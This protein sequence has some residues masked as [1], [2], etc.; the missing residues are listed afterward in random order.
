MSI[1]S[2]GYY[3]L[4]LEEKGENLMPIIRCY[5][6]RNNEHGATLIEYAL[7]VALISLISLVVLQDAASS[8]EKK[9]WE[10]AAGFSGG[11]I[12][13]TDS[14][15]DGDKDGNNDGDNDGN[16]NGDCTNPGPN[17]PNCTNGVNPE[18]N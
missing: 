3:G 17:N 16:N 13:S 9:L 5:T 1:I 12:M 14:E 4:F 15:N 8:A 6:V 10:A 2:L 11:G 18:T 7:C